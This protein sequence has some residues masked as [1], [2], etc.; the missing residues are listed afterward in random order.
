MAQQGAEPA[1]RAEQ[2]ANA[3][4]ATLVGKMTTDECLDKQYRM[5]KDTMFTTN[6]LW[7]CKN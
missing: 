4:A 6:K 1:V 2:E 7:I 5:N 3:L